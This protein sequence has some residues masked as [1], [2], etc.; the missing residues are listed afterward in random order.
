MITVITALTLH[1]CRHKCKYTISA[2]EAMRHT[3]CGPN[4]THKTLCTVLCQ[5]RGSTDPSTEGARHPHAHTMRERS[6]AEGNMD[7]K[8][9]LREHAFHVS[10][11]SDEQE[12]ITPTT[13][14]PST[15]NMLYQEAVRRWLLPQATNVASTATICRAS[16]VPAQRHSG[17]NNWPLA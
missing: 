17:P 5:C 7:I 12:P 16:K 9:E 4:N 14:V 3:N 15:T 10:I 1:V 2:G 6:S 11:V 13:N 8:S